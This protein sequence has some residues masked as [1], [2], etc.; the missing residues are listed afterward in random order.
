MSHFTNKDNDSQYLLL[1]IKSHP[2]F[3][4]QVQLNPLLELCSIWKNPLGA[5][6]WVLL[7]PNFCGSFKFA[8]INISYILGSNSLDSK[9][10]TASHFLMKLGNA[11]IS[12]Y[13]VELSSTGIIQ[14]AHLF[15]FLAFPFLYL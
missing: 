14:H 4:T 7:T 8:H 15:P 5:L 2:S 6:D 3:Q 1:V 12:I 13:F 11:L 9:E 10:S